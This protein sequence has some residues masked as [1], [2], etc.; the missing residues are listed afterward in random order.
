[1]KALYS[2]FYDEIVKFAGN[3]VCGSCGCIDH[4]PR[5]FDLV[6]VNDDSLRTLRVDPSLIPFDFSSGTA[7]IDDQHIMID[8][9]GIVQSAGQP[10]SVY[11]CQSCQKSLKN[12]VQPPES[13]ANFRWIGP[14]PVEL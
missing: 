1:M 9:L 11:I 13:L 3:S 14:I 10:I 6:S 8:P 7:D 12:N 4:D 2:H 5:R